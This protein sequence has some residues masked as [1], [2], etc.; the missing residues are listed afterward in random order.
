VYESMV[1]ASESLVIWD[2]NYQPNSVNY[3]KYKEIQKRWES[4]YQSQLA[5]VDRGL[6]QSM[7]MAP[8]V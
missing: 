3:E 4:V 7:W 2:K 5:L 6:V 1:S 8:G